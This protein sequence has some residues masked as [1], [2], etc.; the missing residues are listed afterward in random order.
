[1]SEWSFPGDNQMTQEKIKG[2]HLR[3]C[4]FIYK[5]VL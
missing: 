1:M 2:R 3:D 5:S 4:T